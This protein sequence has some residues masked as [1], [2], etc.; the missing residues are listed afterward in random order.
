MRHVRLGL[1]LVGALCALAVAAA[2]ALA[3]EFTA[4]KTGK[5]KGT[6]T[7]EQKF[8][9]GP[10]K[11]TCESAK[12]KGAVAMGSSATIAE[13]IKF[14]KC[15]DEVKFG[16]KPAFV[17]TRF[18]TPLAIEYHANGYVETGTETEEFEGSATL[19]GG[20]AEIKV[21]TG[22]IPGEHEKSRCTILWPEQTLPLK[23]I[24]KPEGEY[25]EATYSNVATPMPVSKKFPDGFQH[26]ITIANSLKGIKYEFEGEPCEEWGKEETEEGGAGT[27]FGS[28]PVFLAG[29]NLEF[30]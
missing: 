9:F 5:T 26:S 17:P 8:K 27:Y 15:T 7:T 29:G 16:T 13:K 23:A 19:A 22:V 20:E 21:Y 6:S 18:L 25:S 10:F 1:V 30:S 28:F 11:I 4:S 14:A 12:A 3:H 24:K 2:P